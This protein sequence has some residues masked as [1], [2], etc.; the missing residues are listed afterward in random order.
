[1][2]NITILILSILTSFNLSYAQDKCFTIGQEHEGGLIFYIDETGEHGLIAAA[3]DLNVN[4]NTWGCEGSTSPTAQKVSIG[5]GLENTLAI[6]NNCTETGTGAQLVTDYDLSGFTDWYLPS[7]NELELLYLHRNII[8]GFDESGIGTSF[9][10]SSSESNF[11][12]GFYGRCY[13]YDFSVSPI[14]ESTRKLNT[15]K[16]N[17]SLKVR[18]IRSF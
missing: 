2:K 4:P 6:L 18:P 1:M 14:I 12:G 16:D 15:S 10:M 5:T 8:G 17:N 7:I 13:G 11:N 9:Y 3:A